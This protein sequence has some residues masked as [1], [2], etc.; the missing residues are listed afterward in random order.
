[1][2]STGKI[3]A[4]SVAA[5]ITLQH[6]SNGFD[7]DKFNKYFTI[8][9]H[10]LVSLASDGVKLPANLSAYVDKINTIAA[11][12]DAVVDDVLPIAEVVMPASVAD[13]ANTGKAI[14]DML[15]N[16]SSRL[17]AMESNQNGI[18]PAGGM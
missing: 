16:L 8:V 10:L 3:N 11:T 4:A 2:S 18:A 13:D 5:A 6:T 17:S 12:A 7:P 14:L 15:H 1:M 9:D